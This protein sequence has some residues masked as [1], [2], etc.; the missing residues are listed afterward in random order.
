ME[1]EI[2][3]ILAEL[4]LE[5]LAAKTWE[6]IELAWN[7]ESQRL[8]LQKTV[9]ALKELLLEA[10]QRKNQGRQQLRD[11]LGELTDALYDADNVLDEFHYHSLQRQVESR[12]GI[13]EGTVRRSFFT[14]TEPTFSYKMG[15]KIKKIRKT[16]DDIAA[17]WSRLCLPEL[18]VDMGIVQRDQ[19]HS[20][21]DPSNVIGRDHDKNVV[22]QHL[23]LWTE[24]LSVIPIVGIEG[25]G[26]TTVAQ[27]VYNDPWVAAHFELRMWV[28]V[29]KDFDVER[30]IKQIIDSAEG[31][32]CGEVSMDEAQIRLRSVL[33]EKRFLLI[34][35]DVWNNDRGRWLDLELFLREGEADSKIIVTTQSRSSVAA[36][37]GTVPMH[38]LSHL[39]F[40]DSLSLFTNLAFDNRVQERLPS[41]ESI[42]QEIVERCGG[43]PQ[44][45]KTTACSLYSITEQHIWFSKRDTALKLRLDGLPSALRQC[46]ALCS[47]FPTN[48]RFYSLRLNQLLMAQDFITLSHPNEDLEDAGHQYMDIL[49]SRCVFQNRE[50]DYG[51]FFYVQIH[52]LI[53]DH[54]WEAAQPEYTVLNFHRNAHPPQTNIRHVSLSE[55]EWPAAEGVLDVL[56]ALGRANKVRTI[57]CPFVRVQTIDEP[58]ISAFIERFKYMRVLDLSYSCFERLPESISDLIHLRLLSLRS[59]IRIRRLPNS[60]CKL[61]N[62]QTLV[63]LDCCEL[64]ELPRD[65]K[66]MISLRH[67]EIT[68]KQSTFPELYD[69]NSLRFLGIVGCISLRSLLREGQSF[70]ALRTLFIHSCGVWFPGFQ[71]LWF[72]VIVNLPMLVG[73]PQWILRTAT[74]NFLQRVVIEACPNFTGLPLAVQQNITIRQKFKTR[75]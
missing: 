63:L 18:G 15:R 21:A 37:M 4:V 12:G 34:L 46:L 26:K 68:T 45:L 7:V 2:L 69:S 73:L 55:D 11:W 29:S 50:Q 66:N 22:I 65:T 48:F 72:L 40:E 6:Q 70:P 44:L 31:G 25:I 59:N 61:Y 57:L 35:D 53:H 30:L 58:F 56:R 36:V 47:I 23:R 10:E 52:N 39:S 17:D 71:T 42:A 27:L 75:E 33:M 38:E 24:T 51:D 3:A 43:V 64:E 5:K 41:L 28:C 16:L 67:L 32:N 74:S 13:V 19:S 20:Y 8:K 49:Y 1:V 14:F 60:I 54:A 9:S 62:L